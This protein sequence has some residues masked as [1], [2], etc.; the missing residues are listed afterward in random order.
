MQNLI[1]CTDEVSAQSN[2]GSSWTLGLG[3][4]GPCSPVCGSKGNWS[5]R[6]GTRRDDRSALRSLRGDGRRKIQATGARMRLTGDSLPDYVSHP[7]FEAGLPRQRF[8]LT[9]KA[10]SPNPLAK[11]TPLYQVT[12]QPYGNLFQGDELRGRQAG[13]LDGPPRPRLTAEAPLIRQVLTG[14][15]FI[16]RLTISP[17]RLGQPG[18]RPS[19]AGP[20]TRR[21][22]T[23]NPLPARSSTPD[24]PAA[25]PRTR[26]PISN[27]ERGVPWP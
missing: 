11:F 25:A 21:E 22:S 20:C 27:R 9:F 1:I 26:Q 10:R 6:T 12:I 8:A 2:I 7:N 18:E 4:F 13:G 16:Y 15:S 23:S 19:H 24:S 3:F 17:L 5:P 14:G